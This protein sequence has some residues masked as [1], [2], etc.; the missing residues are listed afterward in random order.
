MPS[1][2]GSG[3]CTA[4]PELGRHKPHARGPDPPAGGPAGRIEHL[5][6]LRGWAILLVVGIHAAGY[7]DLASDAPTGPL[8]MVFGK[9]ATIAVPSF[10]LCDGFLWAMARQRS[11]RHAA[12][13]AQI[14]RSARRL[15]WPWLAFSVLYT[16]ARAGGELAGLFQDHLVLG[17]GPAGLAAQWWSSRIAMQLYFLPA[18]FLLRALGPM[19]GPLA[20]GPRGLSIVAAAAWF[21]IY[22]RTGITLSGDPLTE[23]LSGLRFYLLG[24]ALFRYRDVLSERA[25]ALLVAAAALAPILL[26]RPDHPGA[27]LACQL[28][29][30][31]AAHAASILLARRAGKLA[32]IGRST[33]GI[34]LLHAP[35]PMKAAQL[36]VS[37]LDLGWPGRFLAIWGIV[38]LAS[39][40]L[41]RLLSRYAWGRALFGEKA[42]RGIALDPRPDASSNGATGPRS[43][44]EPS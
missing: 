31:I 1:L 34:Y 6:V 44:A 17:K 40:A 23:S 18:L 12:Y 30:L 33:M 10:F 11:G 19:L 5:D 4:A 9:L 38:L 22:G 3:S 39:F 43:L 37:R 21:V 35:L 24:I 20:I 32:E 25:G 13:L 15:L 14:S 26:M 36:A 27:G 7:A 41:T 2:P 8:R 28:V 16:L 29:S 42:S